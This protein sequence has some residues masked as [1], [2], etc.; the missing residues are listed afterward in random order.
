MLAF[1]FKIEIFP[2]AGAGLTR[3][4]IP[5]AKQGPTSE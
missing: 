4:A 1:F 3:G 2:L 5:F